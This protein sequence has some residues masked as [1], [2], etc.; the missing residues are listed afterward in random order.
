MRG[1]YA[2]GEATAT[3]DSYNRRPKQTHQRLEYCLLYNPSTTVVD[4]VAT[5]HRFCLLNQTQRSPLLITHLVMKY[6]L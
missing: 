6:F 1:S 4:A 5:V 2:A 3:N